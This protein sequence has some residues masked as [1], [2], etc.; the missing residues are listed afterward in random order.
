[1][2]V[3]VVSSRKNIFSKKIFPHPP[4]MRR[5]NFGTTAVSESGSTRGALLSLRDGGNSGRKHEYI[6]LRHN[7]FCVLLY[8]GRTGRNQKVRPSLHPRTSERGHFIVFGSEYIVGSCLVWNPLFV[9]HFSLF[10]YFVFFLGHGAFFVTYV[11]SRHTSLARSLFIILILTTRC[12]C[13]LLAVL[14]LYYY[15]FFF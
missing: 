2:S 1:M 3:F 11:T 7:S 12:F 9:L 15:Y 6:L 14:L 4:T 8:I 13:C 10:S 5:H